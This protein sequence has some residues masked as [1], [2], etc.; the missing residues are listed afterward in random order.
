L[1][2][3]AALLERENLKNRTFPCLS[4]PL[5]SL[6][7]IIPIHVSDRKKYAKIRQLATNQ[8]SESGVWS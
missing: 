5:Y 2:K 8:N 3:D 7:F 6:A 4:L 1:R